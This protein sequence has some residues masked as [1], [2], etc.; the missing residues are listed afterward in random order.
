MINFTLDQFIVTLKFIRGFYDDSSAKSESNSAAVVT[1]EEKKLFF[2]SFDTVRAIFMKMDLPTV[3]HRV[4]HVYFI[5]S[6]GEVL[7]SK[8]K[9]EMEV[10]FDAIENDIGAESFYHYPRAKGLFL[11]KIKNDWKN[12]LAAF[13]S[14]Q[15]DINGAVDCYAIGH[16]KGSIYYC[17]MILERG[18]PALAKR[19]GLKPSANRDSWGPIIKNIQ[20][21]IDT[22]RSHLAGSPKGSKPL[23]AR[24]AK[25]ERQLLENCQEAATE[26]RYFAEVW[27]NHIAH[28]RGHYDEN[29]AKKVL[30][31]VRTY[32]ET[33][34]LKLKL[35]EKVNA[36][37]ASS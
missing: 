1:E 17:M 30:E 28:G 14:A 18:L 20:T 2:G 11:R 27:R 33:I 19:V 23:S 12:T 35:K 3:I 4:S 36:G 34:S 22:R 13:P 5:F 15:K 32:M 29:D 21:K 37:G 31:H 26:F 10:L 16:D 6:S 9:Q 24:A 25:A 8:L 7:H